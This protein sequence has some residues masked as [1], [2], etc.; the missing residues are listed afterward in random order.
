VARRLLANEPVPLRWHGEA[1]PFLAAVPDPS[2]PWTERG[3]ELAPKVDPDIAD[4]MRRGTFN[5][6]AV[7]ELDEYAYQFQRVVDVT[8][9]LTFLRD[10]LTARGVRLRVAYL[11]YPG[12]VSDYYIPF[13]HRFGGRDVTSMSGP[14]F[15]GQAAHLAEV[16]ARLAVP[17]LDLTP[18]IRARETAGEHLYW[19]YDHH[20]RPAG[21]AFV[22]DALYAWAA[23]L[24]AK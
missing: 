19:D 4:A 10:F 20:F 12:Q 11:P 15:Q 3:A 23:T 21:Y 9:H 24:P 17:F 22:A 6:Y 13:K 1:K 5:P 16:A 18:Q 14:Q 7:D 2:N 8:T